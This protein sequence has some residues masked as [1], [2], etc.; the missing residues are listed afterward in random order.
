MAEGIPGRGRGGR[1]AIIAKLLEMEQRPGPSTS[2]ST[3]DGSPPVQEAV[4]VPLPRPSGRGAILQRLQ[5]IQAETIQQP[6]I[7]PT[8]QLVVDPLDPPPVPRGRGKLLMTLGFVALM[9]S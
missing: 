1:G 5:Q 6:P 9:N 2:S 8:P 4:Q 3:A 7:T